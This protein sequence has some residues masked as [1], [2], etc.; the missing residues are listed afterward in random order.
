MTLDKTAGL[1]RIEWNL[2]ADP[3]AQQADAAAQQA[4]AQAQQARG[5]QGGAQGGA[6]VQ[7]ARAAVTVGLYSAQLG[8]KKGDTVTYTGPIQSFQVKP[9]PPQN[10]ILYR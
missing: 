4:G 8:L 5:G 9:L 3:P 2:Q 7:Q 6:A 10:Y 1:R